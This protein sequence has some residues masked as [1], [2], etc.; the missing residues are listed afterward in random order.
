[1]SNIATSPFQSKYWNIVKSI[2]VTNFKG[3]YKH[4][5]L[6]ILWQFFTPFILVLLFYIVFKT[7]RY[8]GNS[9]LWLLLCIGIFSYNFFDGSIISGSMCIVNNANLIK[10]T[11]F[12]RELIVIAHVLYN[13]VTYLIIFSIVVVI[14][15]LTG[16]TSNIGNLYLI[17]FFIFSMLI[18]AL[19]SAFFLSSVVVYWRDL[20]YLIQALSKF[21]FWVSPTVYT[22]QDTSGEL[23]SLLM[24]NPLTWYIAP[25]HDILYFNTGPDLLTLIVCVVLSGAF[26]IIGIITFT[27]LKDGFADRL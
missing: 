7:I 25:L 24:C 5:K 17:P 18:F 12:P 20:G 11:Y 27:R 13:L 22:L 16:S 1:M 9:N 6:G 21:L 4:S 26:F 15:V 8:T 19:G 3:Q 10:K 14:S 23:H 2:I